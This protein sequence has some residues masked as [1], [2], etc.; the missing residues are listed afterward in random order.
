[1]MKMSAI[2]F[3]KHLQERCEIAI[4]R[5]GFHNSPSGNMVQGRNQGLMEMSRYINDFLHDN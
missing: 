3:L 5:S 4:D 1:M 2:E